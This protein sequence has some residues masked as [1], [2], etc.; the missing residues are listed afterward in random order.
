MFKLELVECEKII[1][2][3]SRFNHSSGASP[4]SPLVFLYVK[5]WG[6]KNRVE[7]KILFQMKTLPQVD[8]HSNQGN[9][10]YLHGAAVNVCHYLVPLVCVRHSAWLISLSDAGLLLS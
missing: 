10:R 1:D 9:A 3:R 7:V 4:T 5:T 6:R 8:V 2:V